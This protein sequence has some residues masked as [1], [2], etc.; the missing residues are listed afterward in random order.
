MKKADWE[1]WLAFSEH[2]WEY[3]WVFE[4]VLSDPDLSVPP[5]KGS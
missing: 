2:E 5:V 4:W 1:Y 3:E